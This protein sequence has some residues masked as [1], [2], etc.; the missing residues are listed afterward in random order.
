[1]RPSKHL[2]IPVLPGCTVRNVYMR[3]LY[4]NVRGLKTKLPTWRSSLLLAEH[5]LVAVTE[6]NLDHSIEDAELSSGDWSILRRDRVTMGGGVL[7][8]ARPGVTMKRRHDLE[9]DRGED[10]WAM[11][12]IDGHNIYVCVV[13][14]KP[15]AMD[16][17]YMTWFCKVENVISNLKGMLII[18]GDLNLRSASVNVN[19]YYCYFLSVCSLVEMNEVMNMRGSKLDIVLAREGTEVNCEHVKGTELVPI[20]LYH[21]P[22]D[23]AI[24]VTSPRDSEK[25]DPS[26]ID[27]SRDWNFI[28]GDYA[29]LSRLIRSA[30]WQDVLHCKDAPSAADAFYK[31]MYDLFDSSIPKKKRVVVRNRRY[32]VWFTKN[33]V[34]DTQRKTRLHHKWKVSRC[35]I[36]YAEF[37][38]L[39]ADLRARTQD[40]YRLYCN[41]LEN[42][43]GKNPRQFW[44]HV[45][46]LRS[47]GGFEPNVVYNG[48]NCSGVKAADAFAQYFS[49]VFLPDTPELDP[50]KIN[51]SSEGDNIPLPFLTQSDVNKAIAK[52]VP[53]SSV[54]PDNIPPFILKGCHD[55]LV[56]P[57]C[58]VF[59]LA[60][61][62]GV[63]PKQL[64]TSRVTPIPKTSD[65]TSV[66]EHRPIAILPTI[67][68]VFE[69]V[70]HSFIFNRVNKS[71]SDAQHGFRP[72]RSVNS[73]LLI[74]VDFISRGLDIGGQV[75]ALYF[76]FRKAFDRVDND[77]LLT[78]LGAIG[79]SSGLLDFFSDY[80]RDRNQFVRHGC[81]ESKPYNTRSGVSQ[82]S[83]LGPPLFLIM[84]NDLITNV[85][86]AKC[87]LYADDLKLVAEIRT[88]EDCK[89]L[90]RDIDAIYEWSIVNKLFFN[91]SKCYVM[92]Y[93]RGLRP[94]HYNYSLGGQIITR[95][96]IIK[97]LG[98]TF[99]RGLTFRDHVSILAKESFRRLG[100]VLRNARDFNNPNIIR[101]LY[102]TLVRSKLESSACVWHPY[103][104]AQTLMLEK[105]QK[106]FLRCLFQRLYHFF[107]Y[108]YPTNYLLGTLGFNSLEVRRGLDQ[109]TVA[110]KTLRGRI[111]CPELHG[112]FC[113][114]YVPDKYIA[115]R[116]NRRHN[117]FAQLPC[118]T[119]ARAESPVCR[120]LKMLNALLTAHPECDVFAD[121][122][123]KIMRICLVFCEG[124]HARESS[125]PC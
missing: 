86:F 71:L 79:F 57:L 16:D 104:A 107:P 120:T 50:R 15:T 100:F 53:C 39:R 68:K 119:V 12:T 51:V 64:K 31:I 121:E 32:P 46:S 80:L 25:L 67:A 73:N 125:V 75:D 37:S 1:M 5:D 94:I 52:L 42:N 33:I 14:V 109:L 76:D 34:N 89:L 63:Y 112:L 38:A 66:E 70:L 19:H 10:L 27:R 22:L 69:H 124:K 110:C 72:G 9:T 54:G 17:D 60:L 93:G 74:H 56:V 122:W 2:N 4:Q 102:T 36:I 21:P 48:E 45:S 91:T 13:Y 59:N 8:A 3:V 123:N 77:V 87:L 78:K 18:L 96:A 90:Q 24:T 97:D 28:K 111:D 29:H 7:L 43:I 83:V 65:K 35:D 117:L 47:K 84:I 116:Q 99:D 85:K 20:D 23:I 41:T 26:N 105:V 92:T 108:M 113:R 106:T 58:H 49:S 62:S 6:T 55:I 30:P 81:F 82:G 98:V 103:A 95:A 44:Q 40:A 88:D 11:T 115:H 101:L 118:K 61:Q 114:V